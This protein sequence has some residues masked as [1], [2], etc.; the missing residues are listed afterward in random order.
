MNIRRN[1]LDLTQKNL[2][3]YLEHS[4]KGDNPEFVQEYNKALVAEYPFLKPNGYFYYSWDVNAGPKE[5]KYDL[6]WLDDMPD[7][8]RLAFGMDMMADLK[9]TLEQYRCMDKFVVEQVKEKYGCY[10]AKTEVL[11]KSG[12]KFFYDVTMQDE[13][14][15]LDS[16]GETLIYQRPNDIINYEYNGDMY[17]LSF[18]GV[19][20]LVTPNHNL[21]VAQGSYVNWRTLYKRTYPFEFAIPQKYFLKD[22]RFKKGCSWVGERPN[23][24]FTLPGFDQVRSLSFQKDI[25]KR[26]YHFE[27]K[28]IEIHSFLRFLGYYCAD[29]SISKNNNSDI[30]LAYN[31]TGTSHKTEEFVSKLISD[32]GEC[33]KDCNCDNST[34][35]IYDVVLRQWLFENCYDNK[36]ECKAWTKKV[37]DFVKK[38]PPEFIKEF[39]T[40]LYLGDGYKAKTAWKL[41]TTSLHLM[42]DVCE[43]L[44]KCGY[45]FRVAQREPRENSYINGR[46]INSKHIVYDINWLK[47]VDAE[48]DISKTKVSKSY[49]EQFESYNGTVYCVTI[50]NHVLYVRRNGKGVWCG[51]SLR[52]YSTLPCEE[53][54][55][56]INKYENISYRTCITCGKPAMYQSTGWIC[57]YCKHCANTLFRDRLQKYYSKD[58]KFEDCFIK[59]EDAYK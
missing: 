25:G 19:D 48:V 12:W 52:W 27:G 41:T 20:L 49:I 14:A 29:G 6:T 50:P 16:D 1:I 5:Y 7:G 47:L 57:P 24:N 28:D 56:I 45:T 31:P 51:N 23:E 54:A 3:K 21:Y 13:F 17:H 53:V 43:L 22:K 55:H 9:F 39:L 18:R 35:R 59:I 2:E 36:N 34:I 11:T 32:I 38:L 15:T 42:N 8:W 10:D 58:I 26:I 40:Y 33:P 46:H 30:C 4:R 44:L 37:P